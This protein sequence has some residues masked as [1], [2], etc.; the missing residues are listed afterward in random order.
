MMT[1][2]TSRD[3]LFCSVFKS[4]KKQEMYL[5]VERK[6]GI[7]ALPETLKNLFGEPNHV[8]DMI[9]TPKKK[10]ARVDAQKVLD[11]IR[12]HGFYLQMPPVKEDDT[13]DL[14]PAPKDSLH[15]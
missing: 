1:N 13:V 6:K 10:L 14:Y 4:P 7:A 15:G 12:I 2:Y 9:L 5:Y 11:E 3:K 8:L